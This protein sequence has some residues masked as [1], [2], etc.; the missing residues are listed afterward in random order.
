MLVSSI[1]NCNHEVAKM[2]VDNKLSAGHC[3]ALLG[4]EEKSAVETLAVLV[5]EKNLSVRDTEELVKKANKIIDSIEERIDRNN[6]FQLMCD[7]DDRLA[8]IAHF[9]QRIK[10]NFRFLRRQHG[11]RFIQYQ[12][13]RAQINGAENFHALLFAN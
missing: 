10:E 1:W 3:R 11:S 9:A 8:V 13:L 7:K 2:L 5:Y 4:L 12:N 6:F